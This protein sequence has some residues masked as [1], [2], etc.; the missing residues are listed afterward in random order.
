VAKNLDVQKTVTALVDTY[1]TL[2]AVHFACADPFIAQ[3]CVESMA[4]LAESFP[5][6]KTLEEFMA[7]AKQEL[8]PQKPKAAPGNVIPFLS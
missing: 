8:A 6:L 4:A 1:T 5:F 2:W 3:S 7:A